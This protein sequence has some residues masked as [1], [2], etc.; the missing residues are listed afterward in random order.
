MDSLHLTASKVPKSVL[1]A[2]FVLDALMIGIGRNICLDI[3]GRFRPELHE[4]AANKE[5]E[6][7]QE[8]M[9]IVKQKKKT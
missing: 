1:A 9:K 8:M 3:F 7:S 5:D 2:L 6:S 4:I